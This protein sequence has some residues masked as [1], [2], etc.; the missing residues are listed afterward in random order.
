VAAGETGAEER[1]TAEAHRFFA[2]T[3]GQDPLA[4]SGRVAPLRRHA[5][6]GKR[7]ALKQRLQLRLRHP[8][9]SLNTRGLA[10][11]VRL[12]PRR[13]ERGQHTAQHIPEPFTLARRHAVGDSHCGQEAACAR[14]WRQEPSAGA[15][16]R[17]APR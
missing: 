7:G 3:C 16:A 13:M 14:R 4:Q 10:R 5:P 11:S 17:D 15:R 2:A 8:Q 6:E 12:Q 9:R 1:G